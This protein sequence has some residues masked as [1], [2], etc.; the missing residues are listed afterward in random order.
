MFLE[1]SGG[2]GEVAFCGFGFMED[3]GLSF[4]WGLEV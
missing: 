2:V 3:D 4:F 1:Q